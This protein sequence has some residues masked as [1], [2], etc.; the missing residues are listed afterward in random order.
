MQNLLFKILED[1]SRIKDQ[2][3]LQFKNVFSTFFQA[4]FRSKFD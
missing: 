1:K 2:W 3:F 4:K